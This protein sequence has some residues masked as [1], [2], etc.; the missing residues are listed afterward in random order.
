MKVEIEEKGGL[1]YNRLE[2]LVSC[3]DSS[4]EDF[5]HIPE[6]Q[7][8]VIDLKSVD[9]TSNHGLHFGPEFCSIAVVQIVEDVALILLEF[10]V[11]VFGS[12]KYTIKSL[13]GSRKKKSWS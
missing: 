4:A 1:L 13:L 5:A 3:S 7:D 6:V 11:E 12:L 8:E 10:E 9:Y 2:K